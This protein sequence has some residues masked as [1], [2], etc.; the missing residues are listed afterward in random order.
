VLVSIVRN[1]TIICTIQHLFKN[2]IFDQFSRL[3]FSA[4]E[5]KRYI[6]NMR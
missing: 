2:E 1:D 4:T 3:R 6:R 5:A